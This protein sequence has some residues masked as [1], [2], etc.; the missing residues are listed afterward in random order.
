[1][2]RQ[3]WQR[4][5]IVLSLVWLVVGGYWGHTIGIRHQAATSAINDMCLNFDTTNRDT[6]QCQ[7]QLLAMQASDRRLWWTDVLSFALL[8]IAGGWILA[9]LIARRNRSRSP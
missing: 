9:F 5:G 3:R 6:S 7:K 1:M 2:N 8:P 4:I